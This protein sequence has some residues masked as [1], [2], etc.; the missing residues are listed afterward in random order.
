MP[1]LVAN[2]PEEVWGYLRAYGDRTRHTLIA[3]ILLNAGFA[4]AQ[5]TMGLRGRSLAVVATENSSYRRTSHPDASRESTTSYFGVS[6]PSGVRSSI[7]LIDVARAFF[8]S[9]RRSSYFIK[10]RWCTVS[11][12]NST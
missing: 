2:M 3:A 10:R 8:L 1:E 11:Q 9:A 12:D 7:S 4:G 5:I 6:R